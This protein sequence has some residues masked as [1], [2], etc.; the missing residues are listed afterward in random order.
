MKYT[1]VWTQNSKIHTSFASA[2]MGV[3]KLKINSFIMVFI[4]LKYTDIVFVMYSIY[5]M[6]STKQQ[7][8][9]IG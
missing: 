8:I 7:V 2:L 6:S 3:V 1:R 9:A 5:K 4:V